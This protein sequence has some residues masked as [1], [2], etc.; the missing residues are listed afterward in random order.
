[1][2]TIG[3][4]IPKCTEDELSRS[5]VNYVLC[6]CQPYLMSHY[7]IWAIIY[8]G[9]SKLHKETEVSVLTLIVREYSL[10][11]KSWLGVQWSGLCYPSLT[12]AYILVLMAGGCC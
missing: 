6:M 11:W 9:N 7:D 5:M 10:L 3:I 4:R 12:E 1:M 2:T 8:I